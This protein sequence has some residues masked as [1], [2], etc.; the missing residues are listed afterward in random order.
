VSLTATRPA[1]AGLVD[2]AGV[3]GRA[4]APRHVL[5]GVA[6]M[7]GFALLFAISALRADPAVPVL[8]VAAPVA[9]GEVIGQA[10]LRVVHVVPDAAVRLVPASQRES[11]V[12][13][14][15]AVPLAAGSLLSPGQVGAVAWPPVGRSVLAVPVPTGRVP[16]GLSAGSAVS[17][18]LP[19]AGAGA[20]VEVPEGAEAAGVVAVPAVVVAVE[21]PNVAGIR[22]VSLLLTQA[23]ARQVAAA[24]DAVVLVL[25]SPGTG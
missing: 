10:D 17:V 18:L 3:L 14:T 16:A 22:V 9:A 21:A 19:A 11:V 12:G 5:V 13:R 24:G 23:Q 4:R 8:A 25:E 20:Q 1:G 2:A 6:M 7:V 15:A